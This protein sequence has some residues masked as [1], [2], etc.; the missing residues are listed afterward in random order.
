[1]IEKAD[2]GFDRGRASAV[3]IDG[4]LD[5]GFFGFARYRAFAHFAL[6]IAVR[7]QSLS[8]A[9]A[10]YQGR[11]ELATSVALKARANFAFAALPPS[12]LHWQGPTLKSCLT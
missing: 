12:H 11:C 3:E 6:P 10:F 7:A 2:T 9:G 8:F 1:V 4:D 5:I